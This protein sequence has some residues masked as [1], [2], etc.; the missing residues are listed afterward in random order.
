M[1]SFLMICLLFVS[2]NS[3]AANSTG[4]ASTVSDK[5]T[6]RSITKEQA[7]TYATVLS[8]YRQTFGCQFSDSELVNAY[9]PT[10][11]SDSL[12]LSTVTGSDTV[13]E[14][15]IAG[16]TL[17]RCF[18]NTK[19]DNAPKLGNA[20]YRVC[21][22]IKGENDLSLVNFAIERYSNVSVGTLRNPKV[23]AQWSVET[24]YSCK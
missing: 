5:E 23:E 1:K 12:V 22:F 4:S 10:A 2:A 19:G 9:Q 13:Y 11:P 8:Y 3:F 6:S 7:N 18:A 15:V 14:L 21:L 20:R 17:R 16:G 24:A